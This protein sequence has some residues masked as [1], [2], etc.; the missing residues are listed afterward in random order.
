MESSVD[1]FHTPMRPGTL[2]GGITG[3]PNAANIKKTG[4][5]A[6]F[7]LR[8]NVDSTRDKGPRSS[9]RHRIRLSIFS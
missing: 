8:I 2:N 6:D 7:T 5:H 4:G 3:G 9:A 1:I